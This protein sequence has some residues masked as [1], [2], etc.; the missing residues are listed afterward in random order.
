VSRRAVALV[1]L[2]LLLVGGIVL[3]RGDGATTAGDVDDS[4][5]VAVEPANLLPVGPPDDALDGAWYCAGQSSGEGTVADGTLVLANVGTDDARARVTAT[6]SDGEEA[7]VDVDVAALTTERLALADLI[8]AEWVAAAVHVVGGTITVEHEVVGPLGRDVAPCHSRSSDRWYLPAGASTRDATMALAVFNPHAGAAT[9]DLSFTTDENVREPN[10]LQGMLVPAGGVVVVP[11]SDL[12][13]EREVMA[14]TVTTRRGLVVVDRIQ[15]FDG[16]GAATTAEEIEAQPFRR[17]GVTLTPA[18]AAPAEAWTFPASVSSNY[19]AERVVVFNPGERTAE[20]VI[21]VALDEQERYDPVPSVPLDV[22]GGRFAVFDVRDHEAIPSAAA[23][24]LTVR[25][26]NEV[27]ILAERSLSS[28]GEAPSLGEATSTGSPVEDTAWVLPAGPRPDGAD[29]ARYVIDNPGAEAVEVTV[30]AFGDGTLEALPDGR[31]TIEAGRRVELRPDDLPPGR[32]SLL[33]EA[34]GPVVVER[35]L[36]SRTAA[37]VPGDDEPD[38]EDDAE[39][40]DD[41]TEDTE[42]GSDDEAAGLGT[43]ATIGIPLD[44][45]LARLG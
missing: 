41:E 32:V 37:E 27:P 8:E 12:V 30:S 20:V 36:L 11:V 21:D 13:T 34:S 4:T 23:H 22:P 18:V 10:E 45:R 6:S 24:T 43:S 29:D 5:L 3:S 7:E 25:S 16:T 40:A 1:V 26:R 38:E 19:T 42:E 17:K 28:V 9:V 31:L 33:V 14:T 35:R 44:R 15:T 2:A 39:A